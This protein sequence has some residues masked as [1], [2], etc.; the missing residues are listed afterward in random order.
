MGAVYVPQS[1]R[2]A[3][4]TVSPRALNSSNTN[5]VLEVPHGNNNSTL[6][7]PFIRHELTE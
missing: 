3:T 5:H 1:R 7:R 2:G 6:R 4:N